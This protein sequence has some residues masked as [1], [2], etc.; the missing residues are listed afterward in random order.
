MH[1][2]IVVEDD[3]MLGE[4][5]VKKFTEAGFEMKLVTS[6]KAVESEVANYQ[7]EIVLLDIV[8]P[9]MDGYEILEALSKNNL[10]RS[11][12]TYVFSNLSAKEDIERATSLGAKGF[13]TKSSFTPSQ[14]VE[15]V[16]KI[17][18]SQGAETAAAPAPAETPTSSG[19]EK[20]ISN[21]QESNGNKILIIEDE[22]IFIE[23]F[24]DKL[25]QEGFEV[26]SAKNGKWG[27]KEA[28]NGGFSCILLDMMMP[29]MNGYEAVQELRAN[30]KTKETPII[31]LSNSALDSEV[32][33]ALALGANEYYIK[34]QV[35]P[36]EVADRV[37]ELIKK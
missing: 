25:K 6:G 37:K 23:M 24:G 8:L 34:T 5:Y 28:E 21:Q 20:V 26:V 31:I 7:P 10:T 35:T 17:L 2:I 15:E 14:L 29:A 19:A 36:G 12:P 13:I 16:K 11:V 22:D 32:Q 1:K 30:E 18:G 33:Q 9:D 4:I 3:P 27:L